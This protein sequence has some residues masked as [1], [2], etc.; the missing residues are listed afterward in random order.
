MKEINACPPRGHMFE[1]YEAKHSKPWDHGR[2]CLIVNF[3]AP[4]L[5]E[6]R[7]IWPGRSGGANVGPLGE[8][9]PTAFFLLLE[10]NQLLLFI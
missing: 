6:V 9:A 8:R 7:A 5:V 1:S 4:E 2:V 10:S 3:K